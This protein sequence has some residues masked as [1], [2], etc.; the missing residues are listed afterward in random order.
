[1]AKNADGT[2]YANIQDVY[3]QES[4]RFYSDITDA[5]THQNEPLVFVLVHKC[6]HISIKT[7]K[8]IRTKNK[9]QETS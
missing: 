7:N 8:T 9:S 5:N 2:V 1:M 4:S 3:D 6:L